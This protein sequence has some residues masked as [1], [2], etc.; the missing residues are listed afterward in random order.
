MVL[1]ELILFPLTLAGNQLVLFII[2]MISL[3]KATQ[4]LVSSKTF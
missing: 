3:V 2:L 4:D 1:F